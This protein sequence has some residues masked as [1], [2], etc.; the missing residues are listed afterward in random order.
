MREMEM[1]DEQFAERFRQLTR[2]DPFPWQACLFRQMAKGPDAIP[3]RCDIPT[4][5]GKTSVIAVWLLARDV[6]PALPRRLVYVVNRRTVDNDQRA[7]DPPSPTLL[8][9]VRALRECQLTSQER[10]D[11]AER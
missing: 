2:N 11:A 6:N 3:A 8:D 9:R 4:G 10:P 5:L 1:N 7:S